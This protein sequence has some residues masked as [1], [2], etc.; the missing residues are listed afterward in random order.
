[1]KYPGMDNSATFFH[2]QHPDSVRDQ[3][4]EYFIGTVK[5]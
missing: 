2:D 1:M 3:L 4:N 5:K